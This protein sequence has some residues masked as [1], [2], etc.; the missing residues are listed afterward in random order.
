MNDVS[1]CTPT[2]SL[3]RVDDDKESIKTQTNIR[4]L[5]FNLFIFKKDFVNK[6]K[7]MKA[8]F[9]CKST[10]INSPATHYASPTKDTFFPMFHV[11]Q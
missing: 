6:C 11:V 3:E 7:L 9:M 8:K 5:V 4:K 2:A 10:F 1:F